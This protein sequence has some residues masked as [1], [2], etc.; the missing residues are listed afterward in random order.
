MKKLIAAMIAGFAMS[1]MA[2]DSYLYWM[3]D[4]LGTYA[5]YWGVWTSARISLDEGSSYLTIYDRFYNDQ[6]TKV[7]KGN[8]MKGVYAEIQSSVAGSYLIELLWGDVT[9]A[10]ETGNISDLASYITTDLVMMPT[11][12][13]GAHNFTRTG[14]VPEPTSG[15]LSLFGLAMLALKRRRSAI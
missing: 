13:Y 4:G 3:V 8:A 5:D 15:L 9:V 1:A 14:D 12:L 2:V 11:E 6:G 10:T 7:D